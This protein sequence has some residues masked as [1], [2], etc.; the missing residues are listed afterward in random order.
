MKHTFLTHERCDREYCG[1]CDGG[2]GV[3]T[4]CH[5]AEGEL[6]T[7]CPGVPVPVDIREKVFAGQVDFRFGGWIVLTEDTEAHS[8]TQ[9]SNH[10]GVPA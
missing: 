5:A 7:D 10:E 2:L 3:C 1:I 6:T 8:L 4:V 9:L